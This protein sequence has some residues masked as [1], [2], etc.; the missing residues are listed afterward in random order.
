MSYGKVVKP[1]LSAGEAARKEPFAK[2]N[3]LSLW[4]YTAGTSI[5][6]YI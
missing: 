6:K 4:R 3:V 2:Y 5:H 1:H